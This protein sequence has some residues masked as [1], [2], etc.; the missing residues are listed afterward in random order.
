MRLTG[1]K[2]FAAVST[3]MFGGYRIHSLIPWRAEEIPG[4]IADKDTLPD[5]AG[6]DLRFL[7]KT[8]GRPWPTQLVHGRRLTPARHSCYLLGKSNK[9]THLRFCDECAKTQVEDDG[10]SWWRL[11]HNL[12]GV[13]SCQEHLTPL[14]YVSWEEATKS[15]GLLP[16]NVP[17]QHADDDDACAL[18]FSKLVRAFDLSQMRFCPFV[19]ATTTLE[20]VRYVEG[21]SESELLRAFMDRFSWRFPRKTLT[22]IGKNEAIPPDLQVQRLI[23]DGVLVSPL[24]TV[25]IASTIYPEMESFQKGYLNLIKG[26]V[27]APTGEFLP[28][29]RLDR[30]LD[31]YP[32]FALRAILH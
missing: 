30:A 28:G 31:W 1:H 12:P 5:V 4:V 21:C 11:G 8:G 32:Q 25:L 9:A 6:T 18:R 29:K 3:S 22:R 26:S 15:W 2:D 20:S 24:A 17:Y 23:T 19:V 10:F 27:A 13:V 7:Y 14:R 16:H